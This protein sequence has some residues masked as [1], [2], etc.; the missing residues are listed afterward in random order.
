MGT[1]SRRPKIARTTAK[2]TRKPRS[3]W[4]DNFLIGTGAKKQQSSVFMNTLQ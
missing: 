1:D 4:K 2:S 3:H